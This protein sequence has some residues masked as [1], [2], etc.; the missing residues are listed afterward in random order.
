[1]LELLKKQNIHLRN[2]NFKLVLYVVIL[3]VIGILMVNSATQNEVETGFLTTTVKQFIG[4]IGG[5]VIMAV[6]SVIN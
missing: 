6:V 4:V 2:F 5:I 1:M 3:S